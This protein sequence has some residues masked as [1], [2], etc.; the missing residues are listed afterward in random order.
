MFDLMK[1]L[2]VSAYRFYSATLDGRSPRN[3]ELCKMLKNFKVGDLVMECTSMSK[4][5]ADGCRIG[6]LKKIA[7]E[8]IPGDPAEWAPEPIPEETVYYIE[9]LEDGR[10]FRW[11]N[12]DFIR[13]MDRMWDEAKESYAKVPATASDDQK[14]PL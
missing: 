13:V 8:A 9:L 6:V 7:R 14:K 5:S 1:L 12:V 2:E 3:Y 11:H 10:L 4:R